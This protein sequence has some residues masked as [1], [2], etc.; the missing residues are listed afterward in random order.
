MRILQVFYYKSQ[1][2][3]YNFNHRTPFSSKISKLGLQFGDIGGEFH[4][5]PMRR[6]KRSVFLARVAVV[7]QH[8]NA[9]ILRPA[10]NSARR[11]QDRIHT[12]IGIGI[13]VTALGAVLKIVADD[14]SLCRK[15]GEPN[16]D[17]Q[18]ADQATSGQVNTLGKATAEN[19]EAYAKLPCVILEEGK[20]L[21]P[22][23]ARHTALLYRNRN[24]RIA[25]AKNIGNALHIFIRWEINDIVSALRRNR[26]RDRARDFFIGL[27]SVLK[28]SADRR[29]RDDSEV[30]TRKG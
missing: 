11:L 9:F 22:L 27:I 13:I 23:G 17:Y 29:Q 10:D 25:G 21:L 4:T 20:E 15:T 28:A 1:K 8:D 12:G 16:A 2:I 26:S 19:A 14:V 7:N 5:L 18:R 3:F 24:V 30:F 6:V